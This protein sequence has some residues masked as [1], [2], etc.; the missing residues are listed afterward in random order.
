[1]NLFL[2]VA[3]IETNDDLHLGR[4]LILLKA[5]ASKNK[6]GAIDG[7]EKLA[8][9][10]FFLRYPIYLERALPSRGK[11]PDS[12]NISD[13]ER[14]SIETNTAYYTYKPW[15]IEYRRFI[16]LLI[17][18]DLVKIDI[19]KNKIQV[20]LSPKGIEV[21]NTLS[22]RE[23]YYTLEKRAAI[24]KQNLNLNQRNLMNFIYETFPELKTFRVLG[25]KNS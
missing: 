5:F 18:K 3:D 22:K 7:L 19:E 13:Y 17:A 1:M 14:L 6:N 8:E 10:D 20:R 21:A 16:S 11:S 2:I 25:D 23:S 9:L 12:A 4:I 24:V 15:S